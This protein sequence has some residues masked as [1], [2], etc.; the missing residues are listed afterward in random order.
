MCRSPGLEILLL[1]AA[2]WLAGCDQPRGQYL[3]ASS[4]ARKGFVLDHQSIS[5]MQGGPVRLW[6]FVDHGNLYGDGRA[7]GVLAEWWS[8]DG[9]DADTWRFDLKAEADDPVGHSFAVLIAN[10]AGREDLLERFVADARARRATKVFVT[11]RL[12][13]FH[14]PTQTR[15]LTGLYLQV[16]SSQDILL[17]LPDGD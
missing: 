7:K 8:G 9:P 2:A 1:L 13:T 10:D 3:S 17:D 6:G 11:G 12:F 5:D 4:I 16:R 14:A 15:D